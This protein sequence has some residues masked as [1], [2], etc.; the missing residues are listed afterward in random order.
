MGM[1]G[2]QM[3][4]TLCFFIIARV[5]T[6][7]VDVA[8]GEPTIFG[9]P[10][11][12]QLYMFNLGFMGALTTTILGSI[13]WQLVAGS[14]PIAFFSNP[15]VYVFLQAALFLEATGIC[16]AAWFL[17]LIQKKICGFQYDEVYIGTAEERAAKDHADDAAAGNLDMG[18]NVI[19]AAVNAGLPIS[20]AEG[21]YTARRNRILKNIT[22]LREQ[23]KL[24]VT[25]EEKAAFE[26]SL[27][28]EIANLEKTNK[29]QETSVRN[30]KGDLDLEAN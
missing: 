5:T 8:A 9:V 29:E 15:I 25:D 16:A 17:A 3:T 1:C 21:D 12:V 24:S 10:D 20:W 27:K 4:V 26:A 13:A 23:M 22:D 6:I 11:W 2:R 14:F 28:I 7:N 18:T 30:M 19:A